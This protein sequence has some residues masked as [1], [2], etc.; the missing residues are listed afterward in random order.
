MLAAIPINGK[1]VEEQRIGS[2]HILF[3]D[4]AYADAAPDDLEQ[5]LRDAAQASFNIVLH[6]R[7]CGK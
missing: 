6:N 2:T 3:C 7:D 4:A 1:I 5:V